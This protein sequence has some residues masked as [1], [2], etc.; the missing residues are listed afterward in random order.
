MSNQNY[1]PPQGYPH[2][3]QPGAG[4]SQQYSAPRPGVQNLQGGS[5]MPA[6]AVMITAAAALVA[7]AGLW[8]MIN[9]ITYYN[10]TRGYIGDQAASF[11]ILWNAEFL[12]NLV[13]NI[14]GGIVVMVLV[15]RAKGLDGSRPMLGS[16]TSKH[17]VQAISWAI[18]VYALLNFI[19]FDY[20]YWASEAL[21]T[22]L[23]FLVATALVLFVTWPQLFNGSASAQPA[24]VQPATPPYQRHAYMGSAQPVRAQ[25]PVAY[26][27]FGQPVASQQTGYQ[28]FQQGGTDQVT[29]GAPS[30]QQP[31]PVDPFVAAASA[32]Q[33]QTQAPQQVH[34]EEDKPSGRR[35]AQPSTEQHG[36]QPGGQPAPT[37][38][39]PVTPAHPG[40]DASTESHDETEPDQSWNRPE[41]SAE[42]HEPAVG[43]DPVVDAQVETGGR[44]S[45][46]GAD[47]ALTSGGLTPADTAQPFWF[48]V[49]TPRRAVTEQGE[50][51][52]ALEPGQ[53]ILALE[54]RGHEFLVQSY[55]GQR[56]LL[57]ELEGIERAPQQ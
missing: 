46:V 9:D 7:G 26:Q 37:E 38:A 22:I 20:F 6:V 50:P 31:E 48:A 49:Y 8:A 52:F 45:T 1:Q 53:W 5:S 14:G 27:D 16:F 44:S 10:Q 13:L 2:Q 47:S 18:G 40:Q 35:A 12:L 11:N 32:Q 19:A 33:N 3:Q 24:G 23:L 57:R 15:L 41:T 17:L 30:Q 4:A 51:A 36:E 55:D 42:T 54:D 39:E 29:P 25:Q 43:V 34:Q 28:Q 56:G 21:M